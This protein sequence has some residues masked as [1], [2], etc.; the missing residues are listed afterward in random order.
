MGDPRKVRKV[1][2]ALDIVVGEQ[3]PEEVGIAADRACEGVGIVADIRHHNL[4]GHHNH[5]IEAVGRTGRREV[6]EHRIAHMEAVAGSMVVVEHIGV[7]G[8][9][10]GT[11]HCRVR[12]LEEV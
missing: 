4:P 8:R 1:V 10:K 7:A 5:P 6:A 2:V 12:L 11:A 3:I 9:R